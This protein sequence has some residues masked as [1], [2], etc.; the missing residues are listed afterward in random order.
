MTSDGGRLSTAAAARGGRKEGRERGDRSASPPHDGGLLSLLGASQRRHNSAAPLRPS[1]SPSPPP[2][3]PSS[4]GVA[5]LRLPLPILKEGFLSIP[6]AFSPRACRSLSRR[7]V[8]T[9]R[10]NAGSNPMLSRFWNN[11]HAL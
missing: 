9:V 4:P 5:T 6:N 8:F 7:H 10:G 3:L 2:L 11:F 1:S